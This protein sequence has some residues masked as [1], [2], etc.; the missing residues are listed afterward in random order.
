MGAAAREGEGMIESNAKPDLGP[1]RA[2]GRGLAALIPGGDVTAPTATAATGLRKLPIDK[3]R[4]NPK[5]PRKN[6][7][8]M[9]LEELAQ[10]IRAHGILQPIVVRKAGSAYEIVAGERRWRAAGR[11]GLQEVPALV[12][13]LSDALTLQLA[14]IENI[15]RQDLDPLEEA[16]AYG[17]LVREY[18][19]THEKLAEAMGKSRST[20]WESW[21]RPS[22]A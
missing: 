15:Q 9:A 21:L 3:I 10:S 2:L 12:K 17:R 7:D 8:E 1:R 4:P 14:L 22:S 19:L 16:E 18:N 20:V 13:D 5:Q 11:A 6:F